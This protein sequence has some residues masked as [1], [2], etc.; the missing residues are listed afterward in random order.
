[1]AGWHHWLDGRESQ[2]TPGV[3]DGQES[4][5][6]CNSWGRKESDMTEWLNWTELKCRFCCDFK[7]STLFTV[8]HTAWCKS[9]K[10]D[11]SKKCQA[12]FFWLYTFRLILYLTFLNRSLP[13][14]IIILPIL[15]AILL[16]LLHFHYRHYQPINAK[17][18]WVTFMF[19]ILGT[20]IGKDTL[21]DVEKTQFCKN[22]QYFSNKQLRSMITLTKARHVCIN[23]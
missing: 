19:K 16:F 3:G 12:Q 9:W 20:T 10:P 15:S 14:D 22:L 23:M 2:W 4:L 8:L 1:M 18:C 11:T 21:G 5:A 7:S 13:V 17:T 6:C